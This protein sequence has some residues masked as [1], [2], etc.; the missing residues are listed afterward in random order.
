MMTLISDTGYGGADRLALELSKG[1]RSVGHRAIWCCPSW[2]YLN[3]EAD[4]A[5]LVIHTLGASASLLIV[6]L[7]AAH[8]KASFYFLYLYGKI[9]KDE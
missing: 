4:A 3:A 2:C 1:F 6:E 5:G 9:I 7:N 8:G